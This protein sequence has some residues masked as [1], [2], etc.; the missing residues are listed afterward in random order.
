MEIS[1]KKGSSIIRKNIHSPIHSF[2]SSDVDLGE[3]H[4]IFPEIKRG[5]GPY[6]YDYDG[7]RFVDFYLSNGSLLVG[8]SHPKMTKIIKSWLNRGYAKG[9]RNASHEMLSIKISSMLNDE[10][11]NINKSSRW[12]FFNSTYEA[13]N[14]LVYYLQIAL[15][16]KRGIYISNNKKYKPLHTFNENIFRGIE[17]KDIDGLD[18]SLVDFAIIKLGR[19][20]DID[21]I[22]DTVKILYDN[23]VLIITDE[24]DIES[25]IY[26]IHNTDV[27]Q[28]IKIRI[29]GD[30]ISS[31][32][33]FAAIYLEESIFED[34]YNVSN[35]DLFCNISSLISFPP[36]YKMKTAINFLGLLK[37]FGSLHGLLKI[38]NKFFD[39]LNKNFFIMDY[40]LIYIKESN[41][42]NKKFLNLRSML[43][44]RGFYF[45]IS[46][47]T[48]IFI[49]FSHSF[50]LLEKS[51]KSINTVFSLFFR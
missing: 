33:T 22:K 44:E 40:D 23:N 45:P 15:N 14:T 34:L 19:C 27:L 30:F 51:A 38:N 8:H 11:K 29:F 4:L 28:Y 43:I 37:R 7:N 17:L 20:M 32:L 46:Q 9:Y 24:T 36:L 47:N 12:F 49:S 31:G 1:F 48:P 10:V 26:T 18:L 5:K 39:M 42:L 35:T 21:Q 41:F 25:H 13:S 2:F 16:K 50:E 6:L 3:E